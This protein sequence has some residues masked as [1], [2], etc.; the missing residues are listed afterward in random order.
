MARVRSFGGGLAGV[1]VFSSVLF[2]AAGRLDYRQGWVYAAISVLGLSMNVF[3]GSRE[4]AL[5]AERSGPGQGV[6]RWDKLI[7]AALTLVSVITLV[8]AG[9]DSG[10]FRWSPRLPA[11]LQLLGLVLMFAGQ[12]LFVVAMRHN[13]FFSTVARIQHDRG[14]AVCSGGPYRLVRHPGYLGM[15]T[16]LAGLPLLLGS[17]WSVP[18]TVV[19]I[20]LVLL[21]THLEDRM[22]AE[23]LPGYQEYIR[24][25]PNRLI[26]LVW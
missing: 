16:S 3:A 23:E 7:L 8:A 17:L 4:D 6:K 24:R 20:A 19:S 18:P 9:L 25:T 26:P 22:L 14:H 10:R 11:G 15:I 13:R 5:A 2:A 12:L 1:V 21:R